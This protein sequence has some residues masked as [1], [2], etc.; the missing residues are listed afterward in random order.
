MATCATIK[1]GQRGV[2]TLPKEMRKQHRLTAGD[3]MT[4]ID[5]DGVFV[6]SP[7]RSEI[8]LLAD[9]LGRELAREGE[10]LES[11]LAAVREERE[12]YGRSRR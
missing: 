6:L 8:D 9:R 2:L 12:R 3:D 4:L 1:L 7:R 11:M 10:S 5:L